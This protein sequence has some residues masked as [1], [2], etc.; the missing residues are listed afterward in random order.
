M[1]QANPFY[2]LPSENANAHLQ[3]FLELCNTV[4]MEGV[5]PKIIKLHLFPFSLLGRAKQWFYKDQEV[6][7]TWNKCSTPFLA[8]FFPMGKTNAFRGRISNFQPMFF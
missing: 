2:G 4:V 5:A 8:K 6:V 3:H 7:N 1:V